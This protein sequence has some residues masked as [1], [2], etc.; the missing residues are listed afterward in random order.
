M[1][2]SPADKK[3]V[4]ESVIKQY[5]KDIFIQSDVTLEAL[6]EHINMEYE[7]KFSVTTL[8]KWC[9]EDFW[10]DKRDEF[11]KKEAKL[12]EKTKQYDLKKEMDDKDYDKITELTELLEEKFRMNPNAKDLVA[13][14]T[15]MKYAREL[16]TSALVDEK[17][18]EISVILAQYNQTV[19]N[20]AQIPQQIQEAK[21]EI[22]FDITTEIANVSRSH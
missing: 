19:I 16:R 5:A 15:G 9:L 10:D 13:V 7:R 12:K 14:I 18:N 8:N 1:K 21:D 11:K 2:L 20:Q 3:R 6:T 17:H 22:V 4:Q